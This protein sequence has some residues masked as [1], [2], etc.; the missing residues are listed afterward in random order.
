M[1]L[2]GEHGLSVI[3]YS[4]NGLIVYVYAVNFG[5]IRQ[6]LAVYHIAVV[7]RREV[8][9]VFIKEFDRVICAPVTVLHSF[10]LAAVGKCHKLMAEADCKGR[11]A[12]IVK[13]LYL[14]DYIDAFRRIAGAV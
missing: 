1:E 4:L 7:L 13:L 6:P 5:V 3:N 10:G 9:P 8:G 2:H 14:F 12:V 11:Y